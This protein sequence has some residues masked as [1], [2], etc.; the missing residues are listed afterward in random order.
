[1]GSLIKWQGLASDKM[2]HRPVNVLH[3]DPHKRAALFVM[4]P[5]GTTPWQTEAPHCRLCEIQPKWRGVLGLSQGERKCQHILKE[6]IVRQMSI[7]PFIRLFIQQIFIEDLPL[8]W[9]CVIC[10]EYSSEQKPSPCSHR[11]STLVRGTRP[12]AIDK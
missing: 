6:D 4:A 11:T 3:A 8:A 12:L 5:W 9:C 1:M 10:C 2:M 7:D